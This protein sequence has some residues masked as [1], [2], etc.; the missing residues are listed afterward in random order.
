MLILI[1]EPK[2][3]RFYFLDKPVLE[4]KGN[5]SM[6]KGK[7]ISYLRTQKLISKG[8]ISHLVLVR[9]LECEPAPLHSISM[10]NEFPGVFLK[11]PPGVPP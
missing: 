3:I 8:C 9:D 10:G 7:F 11:D 5:V 2:I 6:P 1:I 4:W